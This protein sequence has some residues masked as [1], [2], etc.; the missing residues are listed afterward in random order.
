M[1]SQYVLEGKKTSRNFSN[2]QMNIMLASQN[3]ECAVDGEELVYADA[4]GGHK[5]S[6]K[7]GG[8]ETHKIL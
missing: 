4:E 3:F 5:T 6:A 8:S 2:E 1:T 7:N